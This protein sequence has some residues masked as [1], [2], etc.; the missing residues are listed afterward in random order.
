MCF[1]ISHFFSFV[2]NLTSPS[3]SDF[4][5]NERVFYNLSI[6]ICII[7]SCFSALK[8]L[9]MASIEAINIASL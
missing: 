7:I 9:V 6:N 5:A 4:V 1:I 3:I 2:H 8:D